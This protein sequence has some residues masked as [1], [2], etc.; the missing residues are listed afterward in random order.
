MKR[1]LTTLFLLLTSNLIKIH[2]HGRPRTIAITVTVTDPLKDILTE[3]EMKIVMERAHGA[4]PIPI[5]NLK[6]DHH[7]QITMM[8]MIP[9]YIV[10]FLQG[11]RH[12]AIKN[13]LPVQI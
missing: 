4:S 5:Y 12:V 13:M 6:K 7:H 3:M 1:I 8:T 2:C 11:L 10:E 9:N